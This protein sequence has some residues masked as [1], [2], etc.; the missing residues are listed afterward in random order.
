MHRVTK[1]GT[2]Y[3]HPVGSVER[4]LVAER[5]SMVRL[6]G[7]QPRVASRGRL[8]HAPVY[9]AGGALVGRRVS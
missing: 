5:Q 1:D 4:E 9:M 8:V 3:P 7:A 2:R 6:E